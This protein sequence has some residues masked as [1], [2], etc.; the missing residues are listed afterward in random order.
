MIIVVGN[1]YAEG[2]RSPEA[3]TYEVTVHYNYCQIFKDSYELTKTLDKTKLRTGPKYRELQSKT[4]KDHMI[5]LERA[6]FFGRRSIANANTSQPT[7]TTGGLL[8]TI[9]TNVYDLNLAANYTKT[10]TSAGVTDVGSGKVVLQQN[11][12]DEDE[13][14]SF[15]TN[16]IFAFGS[17][18]KL[19]FCG[20][21]ICDHFQ[22][23]GKD[24]WRPEN[25][26]NTYGVSITR[27]HTYAGDLN[28]SL[29]PQWRQ[30]HGAYEYSAIILDFQYIKYRHMPMR[31]TKLEKNIHENDADKIK[32]QYLAEC[33]IELT[34][35]KV[36]TI[37]HNWKFSRHVT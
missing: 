20:P 6:F 7:R 37:L 34:Q 9:K 19:V 3:V 36:H 13:L 33:G 16:V 5:G 2:S 12:M 21:R 1:A 31:D 23:I 8:S 15:I 30:L 25:L 29:H 24:R 26:K 17:A 11:T 27:Y 28:V 18:N 35:D 14:D 22:R 4:L 10:R 32:D